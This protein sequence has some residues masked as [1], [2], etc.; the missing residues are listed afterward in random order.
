VEAPKKADES[1]HTIWE[2]AGISA[3][4]S[5]AKT[6]D[7]SKYGP[8]LPTASPLKMINSKPGQHFLFKAYTGNRNPIFGVRVYPTKGESSSD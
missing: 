5:R 8:W 3:Q 6:S 1:S 7:D 4:A 2:K